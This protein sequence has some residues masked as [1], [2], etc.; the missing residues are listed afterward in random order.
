VKTK[1]I[2]AGDVL[3]CDG[4]PDWANARYAHEPQVAVVTPRMAHYRLT[5]NRENYVE[6]S[7]P[8][9]YTVRGVLV[10]RA[11]ATDGPDTVAVVPAGHLRGPYEQCHKLVQDNLR[12]TRKR[13]AE[14]EAEHSASLF[15]FQRSTRVAREKLDMRVNTAI[16]TR[17][18]GVE[19][20]AH[21]FDAMVW[22][23]AEQG[24][25]YTSPAS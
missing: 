9:P 8:D 6:V 18:T 16:G 2:K 5:P 3:Y 22:A 11:S 14:Q 17:G 7:Q 20:T 19:L 21:Q 12:E 4:R 10:R 23:L 13:L 15:L 1:D 25:K 24:W